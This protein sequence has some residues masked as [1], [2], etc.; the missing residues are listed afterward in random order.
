[1]TVNREEILHEEMNRIA[2]NDE[3]QLSLSQEL[4]LKRLLMKYALDKEAMALALSRSL[5]AFMKENVIHGYSYQAILNFPFFAGNSQVGHDLEDFFLRY[6]TIKSAMKK[7]RKKM[8]TSEPKNNL[9]SLLV[10]MSL[11]TPKEQERLSR[12]KE[13]SNS[14]DFISSRRRLLFSLDQIFRDF[15]DMGSSKPFMPQ[16]W[17]ATRV[18]ELPP[19]YRDAIDQFGKTIYPVIARNMM[20]PENC[21]KS[22]QSYNSFPRK[23]LKALLY[24]TNPMKVFSGLI[25]L[26]LARPFGA[27]NLV[28]HM[29]ENSFQ[30]SKTDALVHQLKKNMDKEVKRK[31]ETW[32]KTVYTPVPAFVALQTKEGTKEKVAVSEEQL[33]DVER[34]RE[35]VTK[36][37]A[38]PAVEPVVDCDRFD[39]DEIKN[40]YQLIHL[41]MRKRD[42][43]EFIDLIGQE[44]FIQI[45]RNVMKAILDPLSK[46]YDKIDMYRFLE[47][48]FDTW[49]SLIDVGKNEEGLSKEEQALSFH[50]VLKKFEG[51]LFRLIQ[52][53]R[54]LVFLRELIEKQIIIASPDL[55]DDLAMWAAR[56]AHAGHPITLDVA[57]M[58]STLPPSERQQIKTEVDEWIEFKKVQHDRR[59][60]VRNWGSDEEKEKTPQQ[61]HM[62]GGMLDRFVS[63]ITPLFQKLP[64]M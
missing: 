39:E 41:H 51:D 61:K 62:S 56:A 64:F 17:N 19:K 11:L 54:E 12:P 40:I 23:S 44:D 15:I 38:D 37:L 31:I 36:V 10:E 48:A 59:A 57:Q 29:F 49:K 16:V 35:S 27:K 52:E 22:E 60:D 46:I 42:K 1:M 8:K 3:V 2:K 9:G 26:F 24:F 47:S 45:A 21:S 50:S 34:L 30:K 33:S 18:E 20:R 53:V 63:F 13:V 25:D 6:P 28:Q 7:A 58:L 5:P 55:V 14:D 4:Y 32:S 43:D